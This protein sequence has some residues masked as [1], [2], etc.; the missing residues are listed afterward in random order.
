VPACCWPAQG[1]WTDAALAN[2]LKRTV[3]FRN[4]AV[5]DDQVLQLPIKV[6]FKATIGS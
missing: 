3:D 6:G 5:H 4:I 2:G 1:G